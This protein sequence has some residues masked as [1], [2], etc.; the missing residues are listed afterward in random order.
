[1]LRNRSTGSRDKRLFRST[2]DL[3]KKVNVDP[4]VPRGGIR[5]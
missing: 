4:Y 3:T 5:F 1:M 2:H